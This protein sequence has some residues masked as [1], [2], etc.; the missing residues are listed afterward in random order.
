MAG[1]PARVT[2][3]DW[4]LFQIP[5]QAACQPFAC[6]RW[7]YGVPRIQRRSGRINFPDDNPS[8][9]GQK[10]S[11]PLAMFP[12]VFPIGWHVDASQTTPRK[13]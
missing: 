2:R 12:A 3:L 9:K 5:D 8:K 6:D 4:I 7:L 1:K 11:L 13:D 10:T